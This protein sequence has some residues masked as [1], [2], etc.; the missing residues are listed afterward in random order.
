MKTINYSYRVQVK[1]GRFIKTWK[2]LHNTITFNEAQSRLET[3]RKLL[4][5][6]SRIKIVMGKP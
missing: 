4:S 6:P 1:T 3:V 5:N 2:T